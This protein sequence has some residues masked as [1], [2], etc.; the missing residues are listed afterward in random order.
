MVH[1][2]FGKKFRIFGAGG[3]RLEVEVPLMMTKLGF[4]FAQAYGMTETGAL[5]S[6]TAPDLKGIGTVGTPLDHVEVKILD[7]DE[8]GIGEILT[9]GKN[10]MIEYYM[11]PEATSETIEPDGWMHTGDLGFKD[12]KGFISITCRK[13]DIIVLSSGINISLNRR[14]FSLIR[15]A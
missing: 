6:A 4:D 1:E 10:I 8:N 12:K 15:F 3:A 14:H 9:R 13:K 2:P 5:I 7:P 11:N